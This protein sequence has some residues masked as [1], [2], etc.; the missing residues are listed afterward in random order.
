MSLPRGAME[1][2]H[3]EPAR[4]L[5]TFNSGFKLADSRGGFAVG[6]HTYARMQHGQATIVGY[7]DGRVDVVNW[8]YGPTLPPASR[9]RARTCPLIVD[10][11][12]PSPNIA[13]TAEWGATVGQR[14]ARVALGRSAWTRTAT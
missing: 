6:G 13:N 1:V 12:R 10:G 3:C 5:A 14:G 11:G 9:S 2:P 8:T 7:T 4:L